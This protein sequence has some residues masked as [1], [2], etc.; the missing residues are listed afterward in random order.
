MQVQAESIQS[1]FLNQIKEK[2]APNLS[3]ADEVAELLHISRDSAYRRIRG[4]TILSLDE[5]QTLCN[6]FGISIDQL[7]S[8]SSEMVSFHRLVVDFH[9]NNLLKWVGSIIRNLEFI[10]SFK[11][12]EM[13][14]CAKDIPAFHY[15]RLPDLAA[16]KHFFWMKTLIDYPEYKDRK[17]KPGVVPKELV[18]GSEKIWNMYSSLSST[19]IWNEQA[20]YCTL[21]QIEFYYECRFFES[22]DVAQHLCDQLIKLVDL[23]QAEAAVGK[24]SGGGVFNLYNNEILIADNT[25][26]AKMDSKRCVFVNQNTLT[27]LRT[28]QEPFCEQTEAYLLNLIEKSILISKTGERERNR[29]FNAM[30]ERIKG[31]KE[32]LK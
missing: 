2:L 26:F 13:I 32:R 3:F 6:H 8:K 11:Q 29:F 28:F 31:F 9:E 15:F 7:F 22:P 19:E 17:F 10:S 30:R 18:T 12:N 4:E 5:A 16:F 1:A 24:K 20:I 27:I 21:R 23:V 25:V 14:F